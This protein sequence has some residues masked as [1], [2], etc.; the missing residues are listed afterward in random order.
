MIEKIFLPN[1]DVLGGSLES[2]ASVQPMSNADLLCLICIFV[3]YVTLSFCILALF[4]SLHLSF[5]FLFVCTFSLEF[6]KVKMF[7]VVHT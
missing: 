5:A 4:A 7:V 2:K 1:R 6:F 3:L